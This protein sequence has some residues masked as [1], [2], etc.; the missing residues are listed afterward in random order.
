MNLKQLVSEM[1]TTA[2]L[3]GNEI[4]KNFLKMIRRKFIDDDEKYEAFIRILKKN[5]FKKKG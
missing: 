1:V 2:N 3:S 5:G 4:P